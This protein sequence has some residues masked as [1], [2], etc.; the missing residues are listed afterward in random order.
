MIH[1]FKEIRVIK[2]H[3]DTSEELTQHIEDP[4]A[5]AKL[6]LSFQSKMLLKVFN[7]LKED[8]QLVKNKNSVNIDK[9][10]SYGYII[11]KKNNITT[12]YF[13][14]YPQEPNKINFGREI[15]ADIEPQ[16][17]LGILQRRLEMDKSLVVNKTVTA[18]GE[19][20]T[21]IIK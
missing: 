16:I 19:N 4:A 13:Q 10:V 12:I 17:Y 7:Q 5:R 11:S 20:L 1:G 18:D 9:A 2:E 6:E 15:K 3:K 14:A 21:L 8:L